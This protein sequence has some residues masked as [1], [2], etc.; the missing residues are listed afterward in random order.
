MFH[1]FYIIEGVNSGKLSQIPI[2]LNTLLWITLATL[3]SFIS[4]L[5]NAIAWK[6]LLRWLGYDSTR[7]GL[8]SL[9]L[10]SNLLKYLPGGIWHFL[11]RFRVLKKYMKPEK[12]FYS[13]L[14]ELFFMII[15]ALCLVNALLPFGSLSAS[16]PKVVYFPNTLV[17]STSEFL[18]LCLKFGIL[19][20]RIYLQYILHP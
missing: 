6:N 16:S 12:A 19:L 15:S 14:L 20:F 2:S 5:V 10:N 4:L 1:A 3:I 13:V 17:I 9:Y 8:L 11:E 7:I 18:V